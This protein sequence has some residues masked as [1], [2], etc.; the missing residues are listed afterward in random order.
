MRRCFDLSLRIKI[1]LW[2][3]GLIVV[4]ALTVSLVLVAQAYDGLRQDILNSS[5]SLG[6]ALA[7]NVFPAMLNDEVW[8]AFEIIRAPLS[9]TSSENNVQP[10]ILLAVNQRLQV[11]VATDPVAAPLS[12]QMAEIGADYAGLAQ[13]LAVAEETATVEYI[14]E[15]HLYV[16]VP[17]SDEGMRLGTLI[18]VHSKEALLPRFWSVARHGALAGL[19]VLALLL[20]INWYWGRRM[21][22]PLV[23]LARS[24]DSVAEG[25]NPP[26]PTAYRYRDELGRLFDAYGL[27]VGALHDKSRLEQEVIRSERLAAIGRLSAGLAHE[28]NNPLGG[29]LLALDNFKRRGGHDER[30]LK[31]VAMIERGLSQIRETVG[32]ML[33]EAKVRS[34]DF[35]PQDVDDLATLLAA[36]AR[37]RVVIVDIDSHLDSTVPLPAT[38]LR[39]ILMNLLLNAVQASEPS[40]RVY[41]TLRYAHGSLMI[42]V[43]NAGQAISEEVMSRLFEP[44]ANGRE[45]GS[46][47]GLWVTYQIVSQLGGQIVAENIAGVTRFSVVL[48]TGEPA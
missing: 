20:P 43:R 26:P 16:A 24:I 44:F 23:D 36:E 4:T 48:P 25:A 34:R 33:V 1:P 7:K 47:L 15:H 13:R 27:M 9:G 17:I 40:T 3:S 21:A 11:F 39:Q 38:L 2:G 18:V 10:E 22:D 5:A 45:N 12:V 14:G 42:E 29:M 28:I 41:C 30:T 8:R 6:R 31:M 32:A 46:G 19:L 37:K 35:S